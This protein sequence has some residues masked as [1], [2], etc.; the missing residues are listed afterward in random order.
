MVKKILNAQQTM[1]KNE[2]ADSC[3]FNFS[4]RHPPSVG[5]MDQYIKNCSEYDVERGDVF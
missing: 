4:L 5:R 2:L 3:H 1:Y